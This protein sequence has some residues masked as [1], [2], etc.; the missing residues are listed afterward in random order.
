MSQLCGK[1]HNLCCPTVVSPGTKRVNG[2]HVMGA[3]IIALGR[4]EFF[5]TDEDLQTYD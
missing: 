5:D 1:G 3:L 4:P 2:A